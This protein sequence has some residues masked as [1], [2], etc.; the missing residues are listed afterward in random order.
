MKKADALA[1]WRSLPE[2]LEILPHMTPIPYKA[3][4]SSYG[5]CGIRI[6]GN[7]EFV[8]AVLSR[9][10]DLLDGENTVTRLGLARAPVAPR[11]VGGKMRTY[12]K[13]AKQAECCYV[14]LHMRGAEGGI[15]EAY[16]PKSREAT[17]RYA[18]AIG[19]DE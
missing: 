19:A 4:G 8:N 17:A 18:R 11:E 5:A 7:P 6:D 14:R 2:G 12:S 16:N 15:A 10:K 3:A 9:L 1:H 13:A